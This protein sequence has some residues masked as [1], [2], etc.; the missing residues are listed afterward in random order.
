MLHVVPV[1]IGRRILCLLGIGTAA[2]ATWHCVRLARADA[3]FRKLT[4]EEL[5]RAAALDGGNSLY[6]TTLAQLK[7]PGPLLERAAAV[8]PYDSSIRIRLGLHAEAAGDHLA[9]ERHLLEAVNLNRKFDPRWALANYYFRRDDRAQFRR[10]AR[11]ALE[12]S[13]GDRSPLFDLCAAMSQDFAEVVR[14]ILPTRRDVRIAFVQYAAAHSRVREVAALVEELARSAPQSEIPA[15]AAL[16]QALLAEYS[17]P[18]ALRCSANLSSEDAFPW[19]AHDAR[20]IGVYPRS[21]GGWSVSLDGTQP[22]QVVLLSKIEPVSGGRCRLDV[23]WDTPPRG[24]EW[25][26]ERHTREGGR[27]PLEFD[28]PPGRAAVRLSLRYQRSPGDTRYE[29][30]VEIEHARVNCSP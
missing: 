3:H 20:G 25:W 6:L 11:E 5:E 9:A 8:N 27:L 15:H 28:A 10:W 22:E 4:L 1:S 29:G 30:T 12:I 16:C 17:V 14:E 19:Q 21:N 13:Y 2:F 23:R 7:T 24:L 18:E 26:V